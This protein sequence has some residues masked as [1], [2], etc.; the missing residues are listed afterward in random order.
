MLFPTNQKEVNAVKAVKAKKKQ[1]V[2]KHL[3][4]NLFLI[5]VKNICTFFFM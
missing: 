3:K 5:L 1:N 2:E 4:K